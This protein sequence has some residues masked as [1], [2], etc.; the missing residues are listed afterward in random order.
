MAEELASATLCR[1]YLQ[2]TLR[3]YYRLMHDSNKI[4]TYTKKV[5]DSGIAPRQ[6]V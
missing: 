2:N 3:K 5:N 1:N 4:N 6:I